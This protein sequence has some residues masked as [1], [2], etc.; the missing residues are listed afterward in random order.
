V[1]IKYHK[2]LKKTTNPRNNRKRGLI[3]YVLRY[4]PNLFKGA[5]CAG[6]DTEV[7]YPAKELFSADEERMF[8]RMCTD[9]PAMDA[10]LEWGIASERWGVW[11]GTTPPM[12]AKIR[13]ELGVEVADPTISGL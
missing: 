4:N 1:E 7:F 9:C 8:T 11:G 10:C 6:V 13:K 5:V 2:L 3:Q 12:R